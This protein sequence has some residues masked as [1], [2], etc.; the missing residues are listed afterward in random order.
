MFIKSPLDCKNKRINY[1]RKGGD[2]HDDRQY[3]QEAR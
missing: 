2:L 1:Q 3:F